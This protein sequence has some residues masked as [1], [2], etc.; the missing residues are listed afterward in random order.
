MTKRIG[1]N[2]SKVVDMIG[3]L[4]RAPRTVAEL[5]ELTGIS[6]YGIYP[7]LYLMMEEGLLRRENVSRM[8]RLYRYYW[9][10]PQ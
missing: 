6:R 3:L 1:L 8:R 5:S 10:P 2:Q 9:S 4:V 7:W